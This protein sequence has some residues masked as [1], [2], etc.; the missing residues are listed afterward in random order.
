MKKNN[1]ELLHVAGGDDMV[2]SITPGEKILLEKTP[3]QKIQIGDVI[4]FRRDILIAHRVIE[5]IRLGSKYYFF[6]IGDACKFLDSPVSEENVIGK[7]VGKSDYR[8]NSLRCSIALR[9]LLFFYLIDTLFL[10][11]KL[12]VVRTRFLKVISNNFV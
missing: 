11:N 4:V 5:K 6:T 10:H 8:K 9:L 7:V 2:P 3:V 1:F 12:K